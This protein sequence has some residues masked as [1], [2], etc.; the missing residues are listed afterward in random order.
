MYAII[1]KCF[2]T[3]HHSNV[4]KNNGIFSIQ[5]YFKDQIYI[6]IEALIVFLY[7]PSENL[8]NVLSNKSIIIRSSGLTVRGEFNKFVGL[9]IFLYNSSCCFFICV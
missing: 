8:T 4:E 1:S 3:G 7:P 2:S 5:I 6:V 9:G